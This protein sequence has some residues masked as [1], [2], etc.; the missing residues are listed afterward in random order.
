M[1][2]PTICQIRIRPLERGDVDGVR[3]LFTDGQ[4]SVA[5]GCAAHIR[6]AVERYVEKSLADD[7]ADVWAHYMEPSGSYFWVAE[8]D[9]GLV[10]TTGVEPAAPGVAEVRRMAVARLARRRGVARSLLHTAEAWVG[11]HGYVAVEAT[12]THLQGP[13]LALYEST[14]YRERSAGTWGP[15]RL[16]HLRKRLEDTTG[17]GARGK[18]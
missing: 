13:A 6:R 14:G 8:A 5:E 10:G 9:G 2:D 12:T 7:L 18:P 3:V 16:I 17:A 11:A 15:L 1:R 4:L